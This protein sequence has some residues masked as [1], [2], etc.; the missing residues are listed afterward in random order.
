MKT[1]IDD[2]SE[3][4]IQGALV[5]ACNLVATAL[6]GGL[7][8]GRGVHVRVELL[9][10]SGL[11][12]ELLIRHHAHLGAGSKVAPGV[13]LRHAVGPL[14]RARQGDDGLRHAVL[15]GHRDDGLQ[16]ASHRVGG[17]QLGLGGQEGVLG[18]LG[19]ARGPHRVVGKHRRDGAVLEG[20]EHL[21]APCVLVVLAVGVLEVGGGED[22]SVVCAL[23][24]G[25]ELEAVVEEDLGLGA[26][27]EVHVGVGLCELL[28]PCEGDLLGRDNVNLV[29]LGGDRDDGSALG[30]GALGALVAGEDL[31]VLLLE[32]LELL[33]LGLQGHLDREPLGH[34][35]LHTRPVDGG[36]VALE[37][38]LE[39]CVDFRLGQ[40]F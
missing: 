12:R 29:L 13:R 6:A 19:A 25:R 40:H 20:V 7:D 3:T 27:A 36:G 38:L 5:G 16:G 33:D 39:P 17:R 26:G 34:D 15:V 32:V 37:K 18:R 4:C 28:G 24:L 31:L 35:A 14:E 30:D 2:P 11:D 8:A 22:G 23:L 1:N 10:H 21:P 9:D